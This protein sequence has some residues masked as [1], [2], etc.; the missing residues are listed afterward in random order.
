M[1]TKDLQ[2]TPA[3]S[4]SG[5]PLLRSPARMI[6]VKWVAGFGM[7]C[8]G[9]FFGIKNAP[10]RRMR[11]FQQGWASS[12]TL[13]NEILFFKLYL[14]I[15]PLPLLQQHRRC[16]TNIEVFN[17]NILICSHFWMLQLSGP[18]E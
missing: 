1:G 8:V 6:A 15:E 10:A 16:R 13:P 17:S 11:A 7:I 9:C 18:K 12:A 5:S 3:A 14:S 2:A 4:V